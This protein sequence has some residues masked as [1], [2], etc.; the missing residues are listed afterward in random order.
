MMKEDPT[1]QQTCWE[2]CRLYC[3]DSYYN[4]HERTN[5]YAVKIWFMSSYGDVNKLEINTSE[6][7]IAFDPWLKAIGLPG[8]SGWVLVT[9]KIGSTSNRHDALLLDDQI[10]YT[11][12]P[13]IPG[14]PIDDGS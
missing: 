9:I 10:A 7:S 1:E 4:V 13:V 12:R 8:G 6:Q 3:Q 2:Y 11:K 14:R 5:A